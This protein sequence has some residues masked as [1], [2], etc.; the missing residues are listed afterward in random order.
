MARSLNK[1]SLLGNVGSEPEVRTTK[2]GAKVATLSFATAREWKDASGVKQEKTEW[3][4][5]VVWGT[6]KSAGLAGVVESYVSKGDKLYVEGRIEYRQY[7]K[8]GQTKYTTE[9]N[10]TDLLLLGGKR[11]G[12]EEKSA[13][14]E[15]F[16]DFPESLQEDG[17]E[18]L[19]F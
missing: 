17:D 19:P 11:D 14:R 16:S 1:V 12:A 7:E 6:A 8:D 15:S 13:K 18:E 10:V 2:N 3:H 5:L 9:I 4:K